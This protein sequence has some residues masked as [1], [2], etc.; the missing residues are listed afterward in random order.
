M[1]TLIVCSINKNLLEDLKTN[2]ST[3]IGVEHEIISTDNTILKQGICK[4]YNES[5][6]RAKFP[7]LCFVHEDVRFW[8]KDW[9]LMMIET[10]RDHQTGMLGFCGGK[11]YP[12]VPGGWLD[13]P[14][15]LRRFSM[16]SVLK[17]EKK[18]LTVKDNS[19]S[20]LSRTVTLDGLLLAMR[21]SIWEEFPFS[22]DYL[23]GFHFYDIDIC[24]RVQ[25]KY[26]LV[27]DHR[28]FIEHFASG[29]YVSKQW[30]DEALYFYKHRPVKGPVSVDSTGLITA[31]EDFAIKRVL[32]RIAGI[33]D[34][35]WQAK[36]LIRLLLLFPLLL[37]R[38]I[39][40][41]N[42]VRYRLNNKPV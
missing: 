12:D 38:N 36:I 16:L 30:V 3:T 29:Q 14:H 4:V 7:Y 9:G 13:I 5:A 1:I 23:K 19:A 33:N 25:T 17:D 40:F 26:K 15:D 2:V 11:Y 35:K 24:L 37:L 21:K 10:L 18:Y 41:Y 28:I 20:H 39:P 32:E 31:Y 22:Q 6:K 8:T 27:I 34:F 42:G